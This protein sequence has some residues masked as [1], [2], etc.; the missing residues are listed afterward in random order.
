MEPTAAKT[1]NRGYH[2]VRIAVAGLLL[3]ASV[4]KCWQLATEPIAGDSLL[5]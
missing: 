1:T 2:L 3:T 4:L 5:S